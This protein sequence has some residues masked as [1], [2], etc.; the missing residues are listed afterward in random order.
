MF[1]LSKENKIKAKKNPNN[2]IL[3]CDTVNP[4]VNKVG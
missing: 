2:L 3:T 1:S 4:H